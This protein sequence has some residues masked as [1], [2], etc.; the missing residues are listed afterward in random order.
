MAVNSLNSN[1]RLAQLVQSFALRTSSEFYDLS[2]LIAP[3][4]GAIQLMVNLQRLELHYLWASDPFV[5]DSTRYRGGVAWTRSL[6]VPQISTLITETTITKPIGTLF[7]ELPC[8]LPRLETRQPLNVSCIDGINT[9]CCERVYGR[10]MEPLREL[11]QLELR[12]L[13]TYPYNGPDWAPNLEAVAI[14]TDPAH[15]DGV[16]WD[17]LSVHTGS[18]RKIRKIGPICHPSIAAL[19][20]ELSGFQQLQM[21]VLVIPRIEYRDF[22]VTQAERMRTVAPALRCI[23]LAAQPNS[24]RHIKEVTIW[25]YEESGVAMPGEWTSRSESVE[26]WNSTALGLLRVE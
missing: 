18:L 9:V 12:N 13:D 1:S 11:K 20:P 24:G 8:P 3:L 25:E 22:M 14:V 2:G 21:I 17:A 15:S 5:G 16:E 6:R 23:V 19:T 26:D 7:G 4:I 10:H